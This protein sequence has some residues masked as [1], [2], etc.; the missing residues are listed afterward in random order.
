MTKE[1]LPLGEFP[2]T[3]TQPVLD[4]IEHVPQDPSLFADYDAEAF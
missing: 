2:G 1:D 3:N 4:G